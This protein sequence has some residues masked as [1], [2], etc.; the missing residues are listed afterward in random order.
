MMIYHMQARDAMIVYKD[1]KEANK[2]VPTKRTANISTT[3]LITNIIRDYDVYLKRQILRGISGKE[4]NS[5]I[6]ANRPSVAENI[7]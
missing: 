1:I 7:R 3:G 4:L 5:D 2:F 6:C